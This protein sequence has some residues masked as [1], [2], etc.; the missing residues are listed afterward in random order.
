MAEGSSVCAYLRIRRQLGGQS[1][2][3]ALVSCLAEGTV[4]QSFR[5]GDEA[6]VRLVDTTLWIEYESPSKLPI[7]PLLI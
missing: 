4:L 6:V 2:H 5:V 7:L 3:P 1:V